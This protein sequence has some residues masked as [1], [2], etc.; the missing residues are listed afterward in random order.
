M[1]LS[2]AS[3]YFYSSKKASI[4]RNTA[5]AKSLLVVGHEEPTMGSNLCYNIK[6][7]LFTKKKRLYHLYW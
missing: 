4:F 2:L 3:D 5:I 7:L 6:Y 1:Y